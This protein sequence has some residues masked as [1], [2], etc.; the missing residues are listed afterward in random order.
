M[1]TKFSK[2]YYL[3]GC[4]QIY[5]IP[6]ALNKKGTSLGF[7]KK[8][9]APIDKNP[10]PG[11][12]SPKTRVNIGCKLALGREVINNQQ[13]VISGL[14]IPKSYT[15]TGPGQHQKNSSTLSRVKYSMGRKL[16]D[17]DLPNY[18]SPGHYNPF[19]Q[20]GKNIVS[21]TSKA[22]QSCIINPISSV[23]FQE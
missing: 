18:P 9:E 4:D 20:F 10:G 15:Q 14:F 1:F 12:Y 13:N 3:R 23:R 5:N 21:S 7:G 8:Y 11:Q 16:K 6:D 22:S 2:V 17:K 19:V